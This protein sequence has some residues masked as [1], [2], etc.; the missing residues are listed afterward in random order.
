MNV[1]DRKRTRTGMVACLLVLCFLTGCLSACSKSNSP[2]EATT[3]SEEEKTQEMFARG[4]NED[5][6]LKDIR[7]EDY[8]ITLADY[9]DLNIPKDKVKVRKN[10][11]DEQINA[12][13]M[14][15]ADTKEIRKRKIKKGDRVRLSYEVLVDD[16]PVAGESV[17]NLELT[18]GSGVFEALEEG[19]TGKKPGKISVDFTLPDPYEND[20]YLS[21]RDA[22]I[23]ADVDCILVTKVPELN[24]DFVKEHFAERFGV[25][26]V[27]EFRKALRRKMRK[28]KRGSYAMQE[29]LKKSE[30][31]EI[32]SGLV[33]ACIDR[34]VAQTRNAAQIRGLSF[35]EYLRQSH[36]ANEE[37]MREAVRESC[38]NEAALYILIDQI[39]AKEGVT[40]TS[41]DLDLLTSEKLTIDQLRS[42]YPEAYLNRQALNLKVRDLV[43]D[44]N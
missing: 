31:K 2:A 13:M 16:V 23:K 5:G 7:P 38:T 22:V 27:K 12:L 1:P 36:Y 9:K 33:E 18:I 29:I 34:Y 15:Y 43:A 39:A 4:L 20:E 28:E 24:K 8:I 37:A 44:L 11:V 14:A 25:S 41:E 32:P 10:D 42:Y 30:M 40:V 6:T 17:N 35:R 3:Q 26:T 19:L 21:G